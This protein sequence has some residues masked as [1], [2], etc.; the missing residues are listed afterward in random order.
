M[1]IP[2][3]LYVVTGLWHGQRREAISLPCSR[4]K[5]VELR[6]WT[7]RTFQ[8]INVYVDIQIREVVRI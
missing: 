4:L 1:K 8:N 2:P 5:A 7:R 3:P 6:D